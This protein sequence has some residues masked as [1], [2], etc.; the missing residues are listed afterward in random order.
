MHLGFPCLALHCCTYPQKKITKISIYIYVYICMFIYIY[1]YIHT[2]KYVCIFIYIYLYVYTYVSI[3]ISYIYTYV[4]QNM[5][6]RRICLCMSWPRQVSS[7]QA[8]PSL[9]QSK[10]KGGKREGGLG[11]IDRSL[12]RG[13]QSIP[14][15]SD[16]YVCLYECTCV[17][18]YIYI[19]THTYMYSVYAYVHIHTYI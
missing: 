19:C 15:A 13:N 16:T 4:Y 5:H 3:Q 11:R 2:C 1:I 18:I 7:A 6:I 9:A 14:Q 12:V 17:Y 8:W 10:S